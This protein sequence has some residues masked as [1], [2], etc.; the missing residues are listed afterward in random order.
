MALDGAPVDADFWARDILDLPQLRR[1]RFRFE[2]AAE[3]VDLRAN[4][5]TSRWEDLDDLLAHGSISAFEAD[6]SEEKNNIV[7]SILEAGRNIDRDTG[8]SLRW[9]IQPDGRDKL[10]LV[11]QCLPSP[12]SRLKKDSKLS[13]DDISCINL[14]CFKLKTTFCQD[15][16][17]R[18]PKPVL[19]ARDP[20][21]V[22]TLLTK[23]PENLHEGNVSY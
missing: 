20:E 19:F 17:T 13:A 6:S 3:E 2:V 18:G 9:C 1:F 4:A 7:R 12:A 23:E 14:Q 15:P 10:K 8:A 16:A 22:K 5:F 11:L 21:A